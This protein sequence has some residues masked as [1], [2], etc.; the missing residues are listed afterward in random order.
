MIQRRTWKAQRQVGDLV[1]SVSVSRLEKLKRERPEIQKMNRDCKR[2]NPP[3]QCMDIF[4]CACIKLLGI[5][6]FSRRP[7][8]GGVKAGAR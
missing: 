5:G 4:T 6:Y 2:T 3:G 7:C 8:E 1:E